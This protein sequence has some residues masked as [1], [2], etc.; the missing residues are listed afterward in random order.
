MSEWGDLNSRGLG[1]GGG[2]DRPMSC[3]Q[4]SWVLPPTTKHK[5]LGKG[6]GCQSPAE[7]SH[8]G[9]AESASQPSVLQWVLKGAECV[10]ERADVCVRCL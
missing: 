10:E 7:G 5:K 9:M 3:N 6:W 1:E 4:S 8:E 2:S